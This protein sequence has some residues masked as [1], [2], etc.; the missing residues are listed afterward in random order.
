[1]GSGFYGG[2]HYGQYSTG[3]TAPAVVEAEAH[4]IIEV[5]SEIRTVGVDSETR[6][7]DVPSEIRVIRIPSSDF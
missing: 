7:I 1:M 5:P 4:Y 2:I 6:V 3:G